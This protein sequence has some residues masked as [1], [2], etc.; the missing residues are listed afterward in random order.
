MGATVQSAKLR[1]ELL[2]KFRPDL[3][4]Y[5][6]EDLEKYGQ[7]WSGLLRPNPFG[8][9]FPRST[10]EVSDLLCFCH[11]NGLAVVPSGGRTGLSGGAVAASGELVLSLEKMSRIGEV[12]P[13]A[14]TVEVEAGAITEAVHEATRPHGLT[15]PV[16][17]ASK[18]S[19]QV[20]GNLATNAGGVR[21]I[22]YGLTRNWVLGLTVVLMDG[23]VLD[24]NGA[25]EKNN[26]GIDLRQL[27]IGSEGTLGVITKAVLKLAPL[28]D[29]ARTRV[30]LFAVQDF[31]AVLS[32]F[33]AARR[34]PFT[35]SAFECLSDRCL[36]E[37]TAFGLRSPFADGPGREAGAFVLLEA[38]E[39]DSESMERWLGEVMGMRIE[40]RDLVLDATMGQSPRMAAEL[41]AL[42]ERVA[43]A[44]LQRD[45]AR[46]AS[47]IVHQQDLS[48]PISALVD[49][50]GDIEGRYAKAYPE[51]EVFVFGHIGDGNLHIFIRKPE[52]MTDAEFHAKCVA[53]DTMLFELCAK[54]RGSVSAEHGVGLLKKP[55]L[56]YSRTPEELAYFRAIKR[57]F[58]PRGLLNPG[59]IV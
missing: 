33:Q 57:A 44:V 8:I 53:S 9:A 54:F 22:R 31:A 26:T 10:E 35:L 58:D 5:A 45:P 36:R 49:F 41:W 25:L 32:L 34:G 6:S 19:S 4:S 14:L 23:T 28:P 43:E 21:V 1:A 3:V 55:A 15:W 17:F 48:V 59:K 39:H 38:E 51:F 24:L 52:A 16:D 2:A 20:G 40:S 7:D 47:G 46:G 27:F 12:D 50:F 37:V 18:G 56:P 29:E 30:C 13:R 42:R 11:E